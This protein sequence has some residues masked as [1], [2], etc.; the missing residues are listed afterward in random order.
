MSAHNPASLTLSLNEFARHGGESGPHVDGWGIAFYEGRDVNLIREAKAAADSELMATFRQHKLRSELV[1]SHIRKASSGSVALCNTH[2][3][4]REIAGR[5]HVFAHNGDLPDIHL[6]H[7]LRPQSGINPVGRTDSEYAFCLLL[8][9]LADLW[10]HNDRIPELALR[11][12]LIADFADQMEQLGPFNFLYSDGDTLFAYGHVRTQRDGSIS[13]PGLHFISVSCD[14]GIGQSGNTQVRFES[15]DV[16]SVTLA[17]THPL[18]QG[19]WKAF[20]Q[21]Q[22]LAI[23][24]GHVVASSA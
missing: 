4:R 16:Q 8:E 18:N 24:G 3:F 1:V 14:Y 6:Q 10:T 9:Q 15:G 21:G 20:E 7:S 23:K 17:S 2:P 13:S 11:T 5:V 22:L 12:S 19:P